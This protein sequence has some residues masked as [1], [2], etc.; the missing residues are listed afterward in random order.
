MIIGTAGHI[1][2]GKTA[3]VKALT[4]IDADRLREE[5]LRG[6]TIDLGF[7]Y[8]PL[9][10]GQIL[11]FVDVPGHEKFIHNMLAG[12]TGID[13]VMLVV[14]ADDGPM[15]QTRE[16]LQILSLLGLS[17]GV[18]A[19][20]K[21]DLVGERQV[22][23]A[24]AEIAALLKPTPLA[25][26]QVIPVC[27]LSGE[28]LPELNEN[29][30]QAAKALP[31]AK[32]RGHFR[33]A[34]DRCFALRGIGVVVTG[35]VFSG[36]VRP[37]DKLAVSPSAITVRVR[38]IHAQNRVSISGQAGQRCALNLSGAEK[39]EIKRGDWILDPEIHAPTSRLDVK[40]TLLAEK[41]KPLA[42]WTPVHFHLGA[43]DVQGRVALLES[44]TLQPGASAFAQIALDEAIGA[45]KGDRFIIR[46]Q[47]ASRTIGGGIVLDPF[48]HERGRR[49]LERLK[50][51]A[52]L[53]QSDLKKLLELESAGLDL[54]RLARAWNLSQPELEALAKKVVR[55]QGA[56]K[57]IAFSH[58]NWSRWLNELTTR[59]SES[60]SPNGITV[61]DLRSKVK[62]PK[63]AFAQAIEQ[64]VS[65][66]RVM[67]EG[68]TLRLPGQETGL[69]EE[70]SALWGRVSALLNDA[71]LKPPKLS[72][73][74]EQVKVDETK[75]KAQFK[76][77]AQ[78]D[79]LR[80]VSEQHYFLCETIA[81]IAQSAETLA[82]E[83]A[84]G[85]FTVAQFRTASGL[86]RNLAV[87][88]LE[89]FDRWGFTL[90]VGEGRKIRR[91]WAV[92]SEQR[93]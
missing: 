83:S 92:V 22:N 18:V 72:E 50:M 28:G 33:L 1:D 58:E 46:D 82:Q 8:K 69:T 75:L 51:L 29:L 7:A 41:E 74:A 9:P 57:T 11:G 3:L 25:A 5:K 78:K 54:T 91:E 79:L 36:Q 85:V 48:A 35:T 44:D 53:E 20:T 42:H 4:G 30:A 68:A 60:K 93:S 32:P 61:E 56:E 26:A 90:R 52:A 64:L 23:E 24:A 37:G 38:G 63:A 77:F 80:Q 10:G 65:D 86:S 27:S 34:V 59:L 16:H 39:N 21:T 14:A 43:A 40:L 81:A 49:K 66:K 55:I 45:L 84:G 76:R 17:R 6:I 13:Y 89:A 2:H 62:L 47:S 70:E 12:A 73:L 87:P 71:K 88:V 15:P 67:R 19:L 31:L